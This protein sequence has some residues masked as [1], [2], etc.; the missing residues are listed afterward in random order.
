MKESYADAVTRLV[1]GVMC[2]NS[3]DSNANLCGIAADRFQEHGVNRV[4]VPGSVVGHVQHD[5]GVLEYCVQAA[6]PLN[7]IPDFFGGGI[8]TFLNKKMATQLADGQIRLQ[9]SDQRFP[10][11][12]VPASQASSQVDKITV[13]EHRGA[14]KDHGVARAFLRL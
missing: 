9:A 2:K 11:L 4:A 8:H 5:F 1:E 10:R 3:Q 12:R 14:G 6:H 13:L 7:A